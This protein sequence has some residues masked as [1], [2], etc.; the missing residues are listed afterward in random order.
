MMHRTFK[1]PACGKEVTVFQKADTDPLLKCPDDG[2]DCDLVKEEDMVEELA[3]VC[4][5]YSTKF[6]LISTDSSEGAM[7]LKAFGGLAALL[8]YRM[9]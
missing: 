4:E 1:C 2:S 6:E 9:R 8:R 7:L 5:S 3:K